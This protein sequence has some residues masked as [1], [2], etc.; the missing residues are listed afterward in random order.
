MSSIHSWKVQS[1]MKP[2][3]CSSGKA[4]MIMMLALNL[5]TDMLYLLNQRTSNVIKHLQNYLALSP[6]CLLT[7]VLG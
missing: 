3:I 5:Y 2:C 4:S 7:K 6:W 1:Q